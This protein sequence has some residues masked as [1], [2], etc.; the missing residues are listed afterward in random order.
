MT[1]NNYPAI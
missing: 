1:P